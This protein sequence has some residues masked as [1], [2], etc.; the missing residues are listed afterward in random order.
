MRALLMLGLAV[1]SWA[2]R[3]QPTAAADAAGMLSVSWTGRYT[4]RFAAPAAAGWCP[5]DTMLQLEAIR[6]D[7]GVSLALFDADTVALGQHPVLAPEVRATWRPLGAAALRWFN[8][9]EV[10]GFTGVGGVV[11]VTR[12]DSGATGTIDVRLRAPNQM[13]TL[14]LTGT[15]TSVPIG[16]AVG[17]CGRASKGKA[18]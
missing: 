11:S 7:T 9:T 2:C 4:G 16:P 14:H 1:A 8:G 3:S 18:G 6:G 13:D 12:T 10:L 17:S 5:A 15:F